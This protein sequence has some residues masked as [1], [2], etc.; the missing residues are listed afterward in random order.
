MNTMQTVMDFAMIAPISSTASF[1]Q[2]LKTN[3][4]WIYYQR[5]TIN[6]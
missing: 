6:I 1:H 5:K 3:E 2:L 4:L